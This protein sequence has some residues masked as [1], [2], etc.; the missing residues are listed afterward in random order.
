MSPVEAY[1][2]KLTD[3]DVFVF[4]EPEPGTLKIVDTR[5]QAKKDAFKSLLFG[6]FGIFIGPAVCWAIISN[7]IKG[8]RGMNSSFFHYH[9][10]SRSLALLA[11]SG[12]S[13]CCLALMR[14]MCHLIEMRS[15]RSCS[16]YDSE[17]F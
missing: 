12:F 7:V 2:Q 3:D 15:E 8:S 13:N 5:R 11:S 14:R 17:R 1:K 4:S 6:L 16:G 9:S 10:S